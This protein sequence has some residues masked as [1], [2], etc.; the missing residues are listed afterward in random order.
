MHSSAAS[1]IWNTSRIDTNS[2]FSFNEFAINQ[3]GF[4]RPVTVTGTNSDLAAPVVTAIAPAP[5]VVNLDS[6]PALIDL[7]VIASD[8]GSGTINV[9]VSFE[10]TEGF[11]SN[12]C[13]DG[14]IPLSVSTPPGVVRINDVAVFD[15]VNNQ[16]QFSRADLLAL[17]ANTEIVVT[18]SSP[19]AFTPISGQWFNSQG[20]G[21]GSLG[22]PAYRFTVAAPGGVVVIKLSNDD[23]VNPVV[24]DLF[25]GLDNRV[26]RDDRYQPVSIVGA[27]LPAGDYYVVAQNTHGGPGSFTITLEGSTVTSIELDTDRDGIPDVNDPDDDNDGVL[28]GVDTAPLDWGVL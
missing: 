16:N 24:A 3:F 12:L 9:S 17:G 8:A 19:P 23:T 10:D 13:C 28:D 20:N 18:S 1:G 27:D 26:A 7:N 6:G 2:G 14:V 25:D 15:D 11:F 4:N 5:S 22:N 21:D